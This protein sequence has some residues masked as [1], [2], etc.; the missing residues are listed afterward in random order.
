[1]NGH[2][3]G[4]WSFLTPH[5]RVLMVIARNPDALVRDIASACRIA[6]RTAQAVIADLEQAGYLSRQR[7]GRRTRYTPHRERGGR[8][9]SE[10]S[11]S[12]PAL[13]DLAAAQPPQQAPQS[14]PQA[15]PAPCQ[16]PAG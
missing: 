14:F 5:A 9:P 6:E 7:V 11:L 10:A 1:M 8:H 13:L 4:R 2:D 12:V 16:D 3:Q 15:S